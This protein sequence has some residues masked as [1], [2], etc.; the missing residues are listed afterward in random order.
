MLRM[1]TTAGAALVL[2]IPAAAAHTARPAAHAS[3]PPIVFVFGQ[4]SGNIRPWSVSISAN[5]KI[6]AVNALT[7][8]RRMIAPDTLGGLRTLAAAEHVSMLPGFS[9]CRK[10]NPDVATRY[11]T[12]GSRSASVHGSCKKQF[13]QLFAVLSAATGQAG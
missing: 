8:A 13:N 1:I 6:A 7:P 5:G 2:L 12:F 11:I 3:T 10:T 9:D 4:R